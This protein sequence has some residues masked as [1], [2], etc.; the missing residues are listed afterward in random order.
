MGLGWFDD[1]V[2]G[3]TVFVANLVQ[4]IGG[5]RY[6][7]VRRVYI[8]RGK[9]LEFRRRDGSA[10]VLLPENY[11]R[12]FKNRRI[13]DVNID[14][15][16]VIGNTGRLRLIAPSGRVV[17]PRELGTLMLDKD[18][19]AV[20]S[21]GEDFGLLMLIVVGVACFLGGWLFNSVVAPM[22]GMV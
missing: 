18:A 14:T 16:E 22:L 3:R 7:F 19:K 1:R 21:G 13:Q 4:D 8:K 20:L 2:L 5:G 12:E 6:R 15:G 9:P 10:Y 11:T 17:S